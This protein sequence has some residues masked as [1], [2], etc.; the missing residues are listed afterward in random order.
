MAG[1]ERAATG[2]GVDT[3]SSAD[4]LT[5]ERKC[6]MLRD[7]E[8]YRENTLP[9]A[10]DHRWYETRE[11]AMASAA[12]APELRSMPLSFSLNGQWKFM[13]APNPASA[14]EGFERDD[15]SV[16]G[17]DSIR[18]PGHMELQG[19]GKPKYVNTIYPWEGIEGVR[20]YDVPMENNPTGCYVRMFTLPEN[21]AGKRLHLRFEGVETAFHCWLNGSYIGYSEDSYTPTEFDISALVRPGENRLAVEVYRYC[22]GTW[23]ECQDFWRMGG[24]VREVR[25]TALP[26]VH[27]RDLD[28][29]ADLEEDLTVGTA[30]VRLKLDCAREILAQRAGS[31]Q[32][33]RSRVH[34]SLFAADGTLVKEESVGLQ[35]TTSQTQI[36][37]QSS[38][39]VRV[40]GVKLWSAELPYLYTLLIS[41]R[42]EEGNVLEAA[43][44]KIGFR[45]VEIRGSV[46]YM[47]GKRLIVRGV[48][49]HEF[50]VQ[51]GRAITREEMVWD[52]KFIKRSNFNAV[53]TCHYPNQSLWYELCDEL[54]LYIMDETNL[55]THGTWGN[56]DE[57][58]P[59][60]GDYPAW[61]GAVL[62]R[63]QAMLER[64]KNHPCIFSWSVGNESYGGVNLFEMSE[65]FRHR[66]GSRPVHYEGVFHD[67]RYNGTSDFESRMYPTPREVRAYLETDPSKP[68]IMC[69]YSHSMGNSCGILDEYAALEDRYPQYCGGFIWDYV[70][71]GLY[72]QDPFG[73]S[74][75]AYGGDFD[76]RPNEFDFCGNGVLFAD[77]TPKPQLQEI[78]HTF[79]PFDLMP[80]EHS[81]RVLSRQLFEDGA[82]YRLVYDLKKEGKILKEGSSAF[83]VA[84]GETAEFPCDLTVP[85]EAGEYT[86][87]ASLVL[88]DDQPYAE[89]GTEICWGQTVVKRPAQESEAGAGSAP[90]PVKGIGAAA[91]MDSRMTQILD[92]G[93]TYAVRGDHFSIQYDKRSGRIV[94]YRVGGREMTMEAAGSLLPNFWRAPTSN[95][96]GAGMPAASRFWKT[97]S[98]YP[99]VKEV[100][101]EREGADAV[102]TVVYGLGRRVRTAHADDMLDLITDTADEKQKS[103][104]ASTAIKDIVRTARSRV[105]QGLGR[106][107]KAAEYRNEVIC[108]MTHRIKADGSLHMTMSLHG[109]TG[110]PNLPCFGVSWKLKKTLQNVQWYGLGPC[111]TM[112]DRLRG[113]RLDV[114]ES[115]PADGMTPHLRP[116]ECGTHAGTRAFRICDA[117]GYGISVEGAQPFFF[118][119][120][121]YT[122]HEIEN[123]RHAYELPRPYATVLRMDAAQSG[124]GGIDSWGNWATEP[125][126]LHARDEMSFSL[127]IRPVMP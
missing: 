82:K 119:A 35:L 78:R 26:A 91:A 79:R 116:Q 80:D 98:M 67:R 61:K 6:K 27:I 36:G 126:I 43:A 104:E 24:I 12:T 23:L 15:Y 122:C 112:A 99:E 5:T 110:Q 93:L 51:R 19:Y 37:A 73:E 65:Y 52:A 83:L 70:D 49:R 121:P 66:D 4:V 81:I 107:Q 11:E 105:A 54:G 84:P 33:I 109:A 10:S 72:A 50:S 69:E 64:D 17:W 39:F 97:A 127:V 125:Y 114:Y 68:F 117:D 9:P 62:A 76:D 7:P 55:E 45:K 16:R 59:L 87:N 74:Y 3:A 48:N 29:R 47:N 46:L 90:A 100:T 1:E 58:H 115:T 96:E 42:D 92:G 38:F 103:A 44:Q 63:A 88:A 123:A 94:S 14:P 113:A 71:Q 89:A 20:G 34:W 30:E 111:E 120:L 56:G 25:I 106:V 8:V 86:L 18:V 124:V 102:V 53:R 31:S 75:I 22:T 40:D 28:I 118:S 60:P 13:Q 41:I 32:L 85:E 77:R 101:C 2:T 95:D 21:F 108:I 57:S